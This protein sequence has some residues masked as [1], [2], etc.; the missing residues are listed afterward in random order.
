VLA[1]DHWANELK[2]MPFHAKV[3]IITSAEFLFREKE[4][5]VHY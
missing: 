5:L 2:A 1:N 3:S 4:G